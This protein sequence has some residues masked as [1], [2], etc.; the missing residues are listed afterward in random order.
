MGTLQTDSKDEIRILT[1]MARACI[2]GAERSI[3]TPAPITPSLIDA[4][5]Y[6]DQALSLLSWRHRDADEAG[7]WL[8]RKAGGL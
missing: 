1:A 4:R 5:R 3:D 6:L 2:E 8:A 7:E